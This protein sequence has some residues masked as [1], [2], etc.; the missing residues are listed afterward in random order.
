MLNEDITGQVNKDR[1]VLT[2]DS[3]LASN[4]L[5]ILAADALLKK[6]AS[7]GYFIQSSPNKKTVRNFKVK[8]RTVFFCFTSVVR[9]IAMANYL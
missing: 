4:N 3:P 9:K 6:V 2:G 7:L 5:G 1:N 8:L